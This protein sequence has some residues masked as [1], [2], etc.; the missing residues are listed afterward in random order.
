MYVRCIIPFLILLL[1]RS[2]FVF[3]HCLV[4]ELLLQSKK[5]S[6]LPLS[7]SIALY[8]GLLFMLVIPWRNVSDDSQVHFTELIVM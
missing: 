5:G 1:S 2:S 7:V 4:Q 6:N 3:E 8:K